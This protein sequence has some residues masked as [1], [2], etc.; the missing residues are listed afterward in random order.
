[1][2]GDAL[3]SFVCLVIAVVLAGLSAAGVPSSPR[4]RLD[5]AALAFLAAAFIPPLI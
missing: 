1:M 3:I 2:S 5:A 4:F